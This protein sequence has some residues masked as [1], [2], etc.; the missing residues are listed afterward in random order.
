MHCGFLK[1]VEPQ[2]IITLGYADE[3]PKTPERNPLE[4]M[5]TRK[6]GHSTLNLHQIHE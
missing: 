3:E 4:P 5:C 6:M 2:A 1:N